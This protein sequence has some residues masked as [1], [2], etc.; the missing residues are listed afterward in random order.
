MITKHKNNLQLTNIEQEN[1]IFS[2][3][4]QIIEKRKFNVVSA[5]NS[6]IILMFWEIGTYINSVILGMER[7]EY[8]KKILSTVSTKLVA[9]YGNPFIEAN[10]YRMKRFA[11]VFSDMNT[12]TDLIPFLS[13]SHFCEVMRIKDKQARLFYAQDAAERQLGIRE[14]RQQIARKPFERQQIANTQLTENSKVPFNVFKDPYL[15]DTLRLKDNFLEADLETAILLELEKFILEFGSGFAFMERQKRVIIDGDDFK[16]DLLFFHRDLRR[17]VVIDL[18]TGK[19]K[20]KYKGQMEL[21][22]KWLDRYERK[23]GE[24]SPVGLILCTE[25]SRNQIELLELDKAGIVVAEYWTNLPPKNLLEKKINEILI[26][27][28]ERLERRKLLPNVTFNKKIN[29]FI[30]DDEIDE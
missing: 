26:E 1:I 9:N 14:L 2:N 12:I 19:F 20:P 23:E 11:T 4:A 15:L 7:A 27:T 30:E 21:Y 29:Y 6:Q 13:W 16:I 10:L 8:G 28:K 25:T 18:K 17:L 22:L 24:N 5:A 3:V